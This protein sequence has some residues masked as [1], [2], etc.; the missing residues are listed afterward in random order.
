RASMR[1]R[2]TAAS[3]AALALAVSSRVRVLAT[4]FFAAC[5]ASAPALPALALAFFAASA[6]F[7]AVSAAFFA[8][9]LALPLAVPAVALAALATLSAFSLAALATL[10]VVATTLP[11]AWVAAL[12]T[13]LRARATRPGAGAW[14]GS[15]ALV[16]AAGAWASDAG[17]AGAGVASGAGLTAS[18]VRVAVTPLPLLMGPSWGRFRVVIGTS[19]PGAVLRQQAVAGARMRAPRPWPTSE[20]AVIAFLEGIEQVGGGVG[21]A[22][23]LDL[24]VALDLHHRAVLQ[25]EA[26]QGVLQVLLLDQHAL[27]GGRVEAE[28]GAALE[29]LLV[30]VAVDVLVLLLGLVL[31]IVSC[32]RDGP[33]HPRLCGGLNVH[34]LLGR[35]VVGGDEVV[36]QLRARVFG[37]RH[38]LGVAH[39]AV[40]QQLVAVDVD[41]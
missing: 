41:L 32:L 8:A 30:G 14:P 29:F 2:A 6:A 20:L 36:R 24:L 17:V 33:V 3:L 23:V 28:R 1:P 7:F 15:T 19:A 21:L 16:S 35:D 10:E 34:V 40:G 25:L 37:D 12:A 26:V 11:R 5:F 31:V 39:V 27:E 9:A 4:A 13:V 18:S 38:G 22:V